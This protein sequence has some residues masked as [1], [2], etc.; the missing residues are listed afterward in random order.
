MGDPI[1]QDKGES[2]KQDLGARPASAATDSD[3]AA[4]S[5]SSPVSETPS[6]QVEVGAT[7]EKADISASGRPT[8]AIEPEVGPEKRDPEAQTPYDETENLPPAV[9]VPRLSRRGLFAAVCL[10]DEVDEPKHYTRPQKWW[11]TFVVA[12]ASVAAPI[13]SNILLRE[14]K[15]ETG[16]P[17]WPRN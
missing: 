12:L 13:G 2:P 15:P 5:S 8:P 11:I 3:T 7:S 17:S 1:N 16:S 14:L 9:P 6:K 4:S 10:M